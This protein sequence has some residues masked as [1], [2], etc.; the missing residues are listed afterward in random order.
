M[1]SAWVM[2][3]RIQLFAEL[4]KNRSD[5][6][7]L[8]SMRPG[9]RHTQRGDQLPF[10]NAQLLGCFRKVGRPLTGP[11]ES[12]A[13][14]L[15]GD[16]QLG[17]CRGQVRA[18]ALRPGSLS[19]PGVAV[20]WHDVPIAAILQ[21]VAWHAGELACDLFT[22]PRYGP[23]WCREFT[24]VAATGPAAGVH[25]FLGWFAKRAAGLQRTGAGGR[26][27][28]ATGDNPAGYTTAHAAR[29]VVDADGVALRA[30]PGGPVGRVAGLRV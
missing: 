27:D 29:T 4:F 7:P 28:L 21:V 15:L 25:S 19:L 2:T 3:G 6:K 10:R 18:R 20:G 24:G 26:V 9:R 30:V 16:S 22:G 8:R 17:A 11:A 23:K 5:S 12:G 14:R 13:Q 1:Q